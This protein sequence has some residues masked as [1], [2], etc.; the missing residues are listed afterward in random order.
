MRNEY[1]NIAIISVENIFKKINN[2]FSYT[3]NQILIM[4]YNSNQSASGY[5][6]TWTYVPNFASYVENNTGFGLVGENKANLYTGE[7]G[8]IIHFSY[9]SNTYNNMSHAT[10][11]SGRYE[12]DGKIIDLL[13]NSNTNNY[14]NY[15]FTGYIYSYYNLIKIYGWND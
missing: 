5:V 13:I 10:V 15:P 6:S 12:K 11:V 2:F 7:E 14:E 9:K 1:I 3:I 8:D 4:S